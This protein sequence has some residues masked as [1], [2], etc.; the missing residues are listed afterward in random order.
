[1]DGEQEKFSKVREAT[2]QM[3][4]EVG[5]SG[6]DVGKWK[7]KVQF[8]NGEARMTDAML[9]SLYLTAKRPQGKQHLLANGMRIP[10]TDQTGA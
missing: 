9:M 6:Y 4:K 8:D 3:L 5:I 10:T 7:N 2:E 1:M